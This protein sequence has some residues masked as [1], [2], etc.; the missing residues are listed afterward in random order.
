MATGGILRP[1]MAKKNEEY[2]YMICNN[3]V[4][5]QK[6]ES[7]ETGVMLDRCGR[8]RMDLGLMGNVSKCTSYEANDLPYLFAREAWRMN[9][10]EK[11]DWVFTDPSAPESE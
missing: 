3:C 11:G 9:K 4:N 6:I 8:F 2:E 10:N 1:K 5:R 7:T